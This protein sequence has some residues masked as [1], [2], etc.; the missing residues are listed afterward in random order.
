ME[1]VQPLI[2][3][4]TRTTRKY[5]I[6]PFYVCNKRNPFF[7]ALIALI[8]YLGIEAVGVTTLA[9][10]TVGLLNTFILG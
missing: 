5:P 4:W 3:V 1:G 6:L 7:I 10:S 8:P 9:V 2:L